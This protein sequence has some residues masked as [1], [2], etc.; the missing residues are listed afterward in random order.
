MATGSTA[1]S[2]KG[3]LPADLDACALA[4][5]TIN[6]NDSSDLEKAMNLA[7][8]MVDK[9]KKVLPEKPE[10]DFV[11]TALK[12]ELSTLKGMGHKNDKRGNNPDPAKLWQM[13]QD[14]QRK[15]EIKKENDRRY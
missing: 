12:M 6:I 10:V 8:H 7:I 9:T 4:V 13:E 1:D 11:T 2:K 15:L 3:I 14:K 5:D